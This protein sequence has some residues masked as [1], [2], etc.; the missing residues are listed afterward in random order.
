MLPKRNAQ[1]SG[2]PTTVAISTYFGQSTVRFS[3][4]CISGEVAPKF[5]SP[6]GAAVKKVLIFPNWT[7][8]VNFES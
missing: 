7:T 5:K 4:F 3:M 6:S 8:P 1:V 2:W